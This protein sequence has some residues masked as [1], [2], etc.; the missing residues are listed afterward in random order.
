MKEEEEDPE[1]KEKRE[2]REATRDETTMKEPTRVMWCF[3]IF[4]FIFY[5]L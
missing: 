1:V 3:F 5:L 2:K 4:I